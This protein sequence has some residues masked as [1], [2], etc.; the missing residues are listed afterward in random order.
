MEPPSTW[1]LLTAS[2][3]MCDLTKPHSAWA[4]LVVQGLV[5][6]SGAERETFFG[7]IQQT[8]A[9]S[10]TVGLSAPAF[11]ANSLTHAGI[12]TAA[13]RDPDPNG[14]RALDR[15]VA[16]ASWGPG[17]LC[18]ERLEELRRQQASFLEWR[19]KTPQVARKPWWKFGRK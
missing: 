4:F 2:L 7:I 16:I 17:A 9:Q 18:N 6:D 14:E 15:M 11:V 5:S 13:G 3:A 8:L 1:N 10:P 19:K 12:A